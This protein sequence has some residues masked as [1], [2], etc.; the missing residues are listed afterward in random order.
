MERVVSVQLPAASVVLPNGTSFQLSL[1]RTAFVQEG[2]TTWYLLDFLVGIYYG[3]RGALDAHHAIRAV[4]LSISA[5]M[6]PLELEYDN[7]LH[8]SSRAIHNAIR[9]GGSMECTTFARDGWTAATEDVIL[10]SCHIAANGKKFKQQARSVLAVLGHRRR[11]RCHGPGDLRRI[12]RLLVLVR[13]WRGR[14]CVCAFGRGSGVAREG[15]EC[16]ASVIVRASDRPRLG[17][18]HL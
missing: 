14:R 2:R 9:L 10:L 17:Q 8:P 18:L 5:L 1:T 12:P 16:P 7:L 11:L 6:S 4:K 13:C 3:K 15:R